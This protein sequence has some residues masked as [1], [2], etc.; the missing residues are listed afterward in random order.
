MGRREI[1]KSLSF[2]EKQIVLSLK[3]VRFKVMVAYLYGESLRPAGFLGRLA[4]ESKHFKEH[5]S[6]KFALVRFSQSES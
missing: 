1:D 4:Q 5:P 6:G 3:R 2:F